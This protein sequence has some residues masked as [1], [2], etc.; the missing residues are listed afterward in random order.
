MCGTP[1]LTAQTAVSRQGRAS[2]RSPSPVHSA[3]VGQELE[4]H[5]RRQFCPFKQLDMFVGICCD[6]CLLME[7][8]YGIPNVMSNFSKTG[9]TKP[10]ASHGSLNSPGKTLSC[11]RRASGW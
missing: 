8:I 7:V 1:N 4:V 9:A 2:G 10:S 6:I 5:Y 3:H 11:A